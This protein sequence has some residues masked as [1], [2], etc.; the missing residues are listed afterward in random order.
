M[1][2]LS[3]LGGCH[4]MSSTSRRLRV[5]LCAAAILVLVGVAACSSSGSSASSNSAAVTGATANKSP[6]LL[7]AIDPIDST[8]ISLGDRFT[9]LQVA[10]KAI[11][12]A[13]GVNGHPIKL[14]L[15]DS[16]LDPNTELECARSAV[17]M[18]AVALVGSYTITN[19][20]AVASVV[21]QAGM[22]D[23]GT[24]ASVPAEFTSPNYFTLTL[25]SALQQAAVGAAEVRAGCKSIGSAALDVPSALYSA[26]V[27]QTAVEVAGGHWAGVVKIPVNT[28]DY[29]TV[30]AQV[31]ADKMDCVGILTTDQNIPGWLQAASAGPQ[32]VRSAASSD[33]L[34]PSVLAA[35]GSESNGAIVAGTTVAPTSSDPQMV[36]FQNELKQYGDPS[37]IHNFYQALDSWLSVEVFAQVAKNLSTI[38]AHTVLAAFQQTHN[39]NI[40]LGVPP[41]NYNSPNSIAKFA[42]L[43][44]TQI[45]VLEWNNGQF[46]DSGTLN[47]ESTLVKI[48]SS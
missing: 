3:L 17:S 19:P 38:N 9:G 28:A 12:A 24:I 48:P 4:D 36:K 33:I 41:I 25:S 37:K 32:K 30:M 10:A 11:N 20:A 21:Q 14:D 16:M 5:P 13:G 23:I 47:M 44:I 26:S 8:V 43:F 6:I 15:C 35:G 7:A 40:G 29:S 46:T 27:Q 1:K 39:L 45:H 2:Q 34:T 22:A 18:G 42:R 31:N